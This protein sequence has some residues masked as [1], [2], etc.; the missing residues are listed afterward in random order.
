MLQ[1]VILALAG[2]LAGAALG[3]RRNGAPSALVF[4]FIALAAVAAALAIALLWSRTE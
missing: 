4:A 3:A 1:L 2:L